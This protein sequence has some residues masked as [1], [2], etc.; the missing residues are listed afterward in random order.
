[1][2]MVF[3]NWYFKRIATTAHFRGERIPTKTRLKASLRYTFVTK[4]NN[5]KQTHLRTFWLRCGIQI[6]LNIF[7]EKFHSD[8]LTSILKLIEHEIE[9]L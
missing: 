2:K 7:L 1:M 4:Q 9:L 8:D 6:S 3:C 5:H